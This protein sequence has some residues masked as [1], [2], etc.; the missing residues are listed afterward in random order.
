MLKKKECPNKIWVIGNIIMNM[1]GII[2]KPVLTY[3]YMIYERGKKKFTPKV[4]L[5]HL[6]K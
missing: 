2:V 1:I 5:N 3:P 6:H 4:S